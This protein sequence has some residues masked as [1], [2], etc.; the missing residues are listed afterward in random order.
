MLVLDWMQTKVI[1]IPPTATLLQCRK[2]FKEHKINR[3][4]VVD[5]SNIVV[6]LISSSDVRS[7]APNKST[8]LE[9]IELLE[10]MSETR[11]R[12]VM[13]VDPVTITYKSTIEQAAKRMIDR[14]VACL[15][16]VNDEEKLVGIITGWDVFKALLDISGAEQSGVEVGFVVPYQPGT[17]RELLDRLKTHGMSIISVLSSASNDGMRQVKIR[18]KGPDAMS[19]NMALEQFRDHPGLRYWARE[20]EFYLKSNVN[21]G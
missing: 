6:G 3:L 5:A 8:G 11:V 18:F 13:V 14:H 2:L 10:I 9:I 4:P 16:V 21:L 12:D 1:S 20:D 7:F 15:P 19:Q 17:L